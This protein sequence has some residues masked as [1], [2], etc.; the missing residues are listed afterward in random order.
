MILNAVALVEK[1]PAATREEIIQG[2]EDNICRCSAYKR[3]LEA[4]EAYA[5]AR[6]GNGGAAGVIAGGRGETGVA[7]SGNGGDHV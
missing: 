5:G 1:N 2:M 6:S 7:L 3:I 4:V